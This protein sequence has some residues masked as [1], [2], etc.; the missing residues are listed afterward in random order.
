[1]DVVDVDEIGRDRD[2]VEHACVCDAMVK[3]LMQVEEIEE[4]NV[5]ISM[6]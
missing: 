3:I 2:V 1:M 6:I 5:G 4:K